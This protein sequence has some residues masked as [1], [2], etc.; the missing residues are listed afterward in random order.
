MYMYFYY[1]IWIIEIE[2]INASLIQSSDKYWNI[3]YS[4]PNHTHVESIK[5]WSKMYLCEVHGKHCRGKIRSLTKA[6]IFLL[7]QLLMP[8]NLNSYCVIIA[9]I[10]SNFSWLK[11]K[12][13]HLK[14]LKTI[15]ASKLKAFLAF[16]KILW[17][18]YLNWKYKYITI[19]IFLKKFLV[20]S[21]ARYY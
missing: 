5:N 14:Q 3:S 21:S 7:K 4:V 8:S 6:Q 9:Y 2:I 16:I 19:H 11:L 15:P 10:S 20:I 18:P 12:C 13:M 1:I 17:E